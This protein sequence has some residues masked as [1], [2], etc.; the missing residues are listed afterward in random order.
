MANT[1]SPVHLS[2]FFSHL[3]TH[4]ILAVQGASKKN[5]HQCLTNGTVYCPQGQN[6]TIFVPP[7]ACLGYGVRAFSVEDLSLPFLLTWSQHPQCRTQACNV[8]S[9]KT[10]G[11]ASDEGSHHFM[12]WPLF[13]A[14]LCLINSTPAVQ[15]TPCCWAVFV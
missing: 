15:Q 5:I 2:L 10:L 1:L 13:F 11:R 12:A 14:F 3:F 6:I 9:L 7:V 4:R 8:T